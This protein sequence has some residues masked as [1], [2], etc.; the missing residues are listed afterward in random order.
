M[1]RAME[2]TGRVRPL[3][4]VS[5]CWERELSIYPDTVRVAMEDGTVVTYRID[6]VQPG[7]EGYVHPSHAKAMEIL[8]RMPTGLGAAGVPVV[9]K[10]VKQE[11]AEAQEPGPVQ[12]IPEGYEIADDAK[13][14]SY[15]GKHEKVRKMNLWERICAVN[16]KNQKRR[17]TEK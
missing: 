14:Y 3:A 15:T 2:K 10:H 1:E 7:P 6:V 9:G 12:E 13:D 5:P 8:S 16:Q 11:E 4:E 17:E